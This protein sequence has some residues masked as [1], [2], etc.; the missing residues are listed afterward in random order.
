MIPPFIKTWNYIH[1]GFRR[2]ILP[3]FSQS[4]RRSLPALVFFYITDKDRLRSLR[5]WMYP[6]QYETTAF[7][8]YQ[9]LRL[10]Q[11]AIRK[12][13]CKRQPHKLLEI[14]HLGILMPFESDLSYSIFQHCNKKMDP[15]KTFK[16]FL[17]TLISHLA[18]HMGVAIYEA[19]C[20]I[21]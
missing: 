6:L 1:E 5:L 2:H 10:F 3:E 15:F 4:I 18:S 7:L 17:V 20:F 9:V 16:L 11:K 19:P 14:H 8:P 21:S 12:S 13:P